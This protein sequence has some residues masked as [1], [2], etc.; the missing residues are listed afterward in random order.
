M[1]SMK[2]GL[3]LIPIVSEQLV[4]FFSLLEKNKGKIVPLI[5]EEA[6]ARF[7]SL[8]SIRENVKRIWDNCVG[9]LGPPVKVHVGHNLDL[10]AEFTPSNILHNITTLKHSQISGCRFRLLLISCTGCE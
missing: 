9:I 2:L 8:D 1:H 10:H 6:F 4:D 5:G 3:K 7:G